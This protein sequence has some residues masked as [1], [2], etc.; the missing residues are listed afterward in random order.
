MPILPLL[1]QTSAAILGRR[2]ALLAVVLGA[3]ALTS[4]GVVTPVEAGTQMTRLVVASLGTTRSLSLSLNKSLIVDLPADAHEVIVSQP[5]IAAA[6]MRSKR[7][8]VLEGMGVGETNIIFLDERGVQIAT[9]EVSVVRDASTLSATLTR[10]LPGSNI[11]VQGFG[12]HLIL[13]GTAI[14]QDDVAKAAAI[15]GQFAGGDGNIANLI[16]VS[17]AQQV[18]LKVTVAE[19]S[20]QAVKQLG[21][22]L[23]ASL[24]TGSLTT[25]IINNPSLGG[26][27]NVVSP[28]TITAG[29]NVPGLSLQT[30]LRALE[31]R[32]LSRTLDQ[33]TL[34]A[35]S[36]QAASFLA[37]GEFPVPSSIDQNGQVSYAFKQFGVKLDF[38]PTVKS[39]GVIGLVVDTSVS[40]PT[41]DGAV[42]VGGLTIPA[43]KNRE[44][45]TQVELPPGT[46]LSIAG[47]FE[48]K[49]R[50][51]INQLPGLGNIPILGAL[52][53]S[54]DFLR[55]QTELVILVTPYLVGPGPEPPLPTDAIVPAGDAEANFLGHMQKL[56]GVGDPNGPAGQYKGSVGFALE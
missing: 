52:F 30:T 35:M 16:T 5:A 51:Q 39:S 14:S 8:A 7:R 25:G 41:T 55:Q 53:R 3:L 22:D 17:G 37:G 26:A 23:S 44:A 42:T 21:I 11:S 38:T 45:K 12:E 2:T 10:L 56:Y 6:S 20:R 18:A 48:D 13:S 29:I 43:T 28:N 36:G 47:L 54:R 24:T 49:L 46:T 32:G 19:V 4:P 50:Q 31:Q 34:T 1:R 15:A 33:P 40:E 27:S 9:L